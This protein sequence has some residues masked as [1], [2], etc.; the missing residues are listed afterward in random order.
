MFGLFVLSLALFLIG[1]GGSPLV[2]LIF[3]G[4]RA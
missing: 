1:D 4:D 3:S 2:S